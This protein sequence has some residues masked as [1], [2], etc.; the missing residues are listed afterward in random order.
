LSDDGG[1]LHEVLGQQCERTIDHHAI[2]VQN[3]VKQYANEILL[4]A[5]NPHIERFVL[6]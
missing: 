3:D 4:L 2:L 1:V 6:K 5:F